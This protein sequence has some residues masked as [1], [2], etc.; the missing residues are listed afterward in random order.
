MLE[1]TNLPVWDDDETLPEDA[2]ELAKELYDI[3]DKLNGPSLY[4]SW[5]DALQIR[6][7][8]LDRF[9]LGVLDL[10]H[11]PKSKSYSG[12]SHAKWARWLQV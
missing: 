12:A 7:E 9:S 6:E 3:W 1:T 2:H 11:A 5:H 8:A 10:K 4:E